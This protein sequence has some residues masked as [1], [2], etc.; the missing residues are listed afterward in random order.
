LSEAGQYSLLQER[1]KLDKPSSS[2][3]AVINGK[4]DKNSKVE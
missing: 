2:F 1:S 3:H 4:M